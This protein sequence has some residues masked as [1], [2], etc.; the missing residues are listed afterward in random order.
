MVG[1]K[2]KDGTDYAVAVIVAA[3]EKGNVAFTLSYDTDMQIIG[4]WMK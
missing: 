3:F 2:D 1:Q 4:F